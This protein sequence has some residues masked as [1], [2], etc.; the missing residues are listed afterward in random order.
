MDKL[1][2]V[3]FIM[4]LP[5]LIYFIF[6]TIVAFLTAEKIKHKCIYANTC[7]SSP[8]CANEKEMSCFRE[9]PL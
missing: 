1:F 9:R 2:L 8:K 4:I 5:T 7:S 3:L 6:V